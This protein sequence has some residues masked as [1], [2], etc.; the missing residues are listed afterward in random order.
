MLMAQ[1]RVTVDSLAT[2]VALIVPAASMV[3]VVE[4]EL[5]DA[6]VIEPDDALQDENA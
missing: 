2:K 3:A 1:V 4:G 5:D 6:K